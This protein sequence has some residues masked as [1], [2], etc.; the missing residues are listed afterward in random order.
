MGVFLRM[1][2]ESGQFVVWHFVVEAVV[3][4]M[5][6]VDIVGMADSAKLPMKPPGYSVSFTR[7][8]VLFTSSQM[9]MDFLFKL[10]CSFFLFARV[11]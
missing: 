2:W 3:V 4:D 8:G 5:A 9:L 1:S 7:P 11:L 6:V 10:I